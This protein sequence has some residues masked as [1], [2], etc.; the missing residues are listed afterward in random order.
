MHGS[1]RSIGKRARGLDRVVDIH[2]EVERP[3]GL[4][5]AGEW[6]TTST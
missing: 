1:D 6:G 3:A 4:R 5:R 2:P